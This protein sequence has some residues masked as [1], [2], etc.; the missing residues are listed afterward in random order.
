MTGHLP[1][2]RR[3]I[4]CCCLSASNIPASTAQTALSSPAMVLFYIE[5][6]FFLMSTHPHPRNELNTYAQRIGALVRYADQRSGPQHDEQWTATVYIN[7]H[8]YGTGVGRTRGAAQNAA[9][10]ETLRLIEAGY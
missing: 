10:I 3:C 9:A 8:V 6:F 5:S 4:M 2:P 7:G 1:L